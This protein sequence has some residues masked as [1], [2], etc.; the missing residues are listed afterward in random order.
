[1]Y[2]Y[3]NYILY[4]IHKTFFGP[5]SLLLGICAIKINILVIKRCAIFLVHFK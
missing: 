5:A 4:Y 2:I 1:M 3:K